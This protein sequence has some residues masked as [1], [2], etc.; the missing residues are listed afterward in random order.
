MVMARQVLKFRRIITN[1]LGALTSSRFENFL[2]KALLVSFLHFSAGCGETAK[3]VVSPIA[4]QVDIY[5]GGPF[6]VTGSL[7]MQSA[8]AFDHMANQIAVSGYIISNVSGTPVQV[9]VNII[10]GTFIST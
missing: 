10:N 2:L 1:E 9:F 6:N 4:A 8:A 5:F 3:P 7:V